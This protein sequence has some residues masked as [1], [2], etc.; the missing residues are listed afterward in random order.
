MSGCF[1]WHSN[2][3]SEATEATIA[4]VSVQHCVWFPWTAACLWNRSCGSPVPNCPADGGLTLSAQVIPLI[5]S[6]TPSGVAATAL[7]WEDES[8]RWPVFTHA[9]RERAGKLDFSC[10]VESGSSKQR[11]LAPTQSKAGRLQLPK[12]SFNGWNRKSRQS[13]FQI[14]S[15]SPVSSWFFMPVST[16][17]A[18]KKGEFF[19]IQRSFLSL[20]FFYKTGVFATL[21]YLTNGES[22]ETIKVWFSRC[23]RHSREA[24]SAQFLQFLTCRLKPLQTQFDEKLLQ[25]TI[26]WNV[27]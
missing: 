22:T 26:F 5:D 9:A 11:H 25:N 27:H 4:S 21:T 8:E 20:F 3:W 23:F 18:V 2:K 19:H 15:M 24:V 7:K 17:F 12:S 13:V 6:F 16:V 10:M 14:E 1:R